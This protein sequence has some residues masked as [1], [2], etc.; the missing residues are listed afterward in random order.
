M[1]R[2]VKNDLSSRT[3]SIVKNDRAALKNQKVSNNPTQQASKAQI[4]NVISII[5]FLKRNAGFDG[6]FSA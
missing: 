1:L 2:I 5:P 3:A 4:N 6:G